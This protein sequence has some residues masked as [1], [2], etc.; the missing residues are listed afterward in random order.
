VAAGTILVVELAAEH[1]LVAQGDLFDFQL[2][3]FSRFGGGASRE[4]VAAGNRAQ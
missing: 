3:G 1:L 4:L 2:D